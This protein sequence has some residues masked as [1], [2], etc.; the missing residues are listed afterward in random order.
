MVEERDGVWLEERSAALPVLH[1]DNPSIELPDLRQ[2]WAW[3]HVHADHD[4]EN[5]VAAAL[6]EAPDAFR[7]RLMCPRRLPAGCSWLACVVPTFE[8]G[9][10]AGLGE[11]AGVDLGLAWGNAA[12]SEVRLP[13]YH[14]W[15]FSTGEAGDFE[16]LVRRLQPRELERSVGRRDLDIGDPGG[17][18]PS[19]PGTLV[20][21]EGGLVS[22]AGRPGVWDED[23][24][25]TMKAALRK[26][27]NLEIDR[28][29]TPDPYHA[30]RDDPVVGPP[31]Y[32]A[33]QAGRRAVPAE[34]EPPLWFEE[35][36]TE[37]HR[38]VVAG[39][40]AEV[41]RNDQEALMAAAWD[42]AAGLRQ[43][44]RTLTSAR[45]AW[46]LGRR[47]QPRFATLTD[48]Q[49]VQIA[50]PA[51]SRLAHPSGLTVKGA[52]AD[53]ALPAGLVSGAFRRLAATV[54]G[55]ATIADDA[56]AGR[57]AATAAV[58]AAA[59][60]D[61]VGFVSSWGDAHPPLGCEVEGALPTGLDAPV[62]ARQARRAAAAAER[63]SAPQSE[64]RLSEQYDFPRAV[65]DDDLVTP[66]AGSVE[67]VAG[68]A[69]SVRAA[70]DPA[71][72]VVKMVEARVIGLPTDRDDDVPPRLQARPRFTTPMCER[73]IALSVE[74]LV[75]GIGAVPDN[76]LGLLEVNREFVEAFLT[77]L[78]YELARE[79]VWRE[80]PARLSATWAQQFWDT[81]PGGPADI[82]PIGTWDDDTPLGV[83]PP[84][85]ATAATLVLLLRG[86]APSPLPRPARL[87]R[88]GRVG[89]R[90]AS[91][92]RIRR[93]PTSGVRRHARARRV[94]LRL[95]ARPRPRREAARTPRSTRAGSSCWRSSPELPGSGSTR[96]A[97]GSA[98]RRRRTG[99]TCPGRTS[100]PRTS[101]CPASWT[102]TGPSWLVA[103]GALTGNGGP[104][105]WGED[106]AAMARITFQRP[107][108]ML[109]H[110]GRDA[111]G[112]GAAA[113][114][115]AP[116]PG[117]PEPLR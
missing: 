17:G 63:P 106:A 66:Y 79:F 90:Q 15:R 1:V 4:L 45:L 24:R 71:G 42:H 114:R 37:P 68:L 85:T 110:A 47:A 14:S 97:S 80:Y 19:A 72:T 89:R 57:V 78:N 39:L 115:C 59:L 35:L 76:T 21:Y 101:R 107:V 2:C 55:F 12:T 58:T 44:N 95:R 61:P 30:L 7:S 48:A 65:V 86:R 50:G 41:V 81:G 52:L 54:T 27:L 16:S 93:G 74:Y 62:A 13:V 117:E 91:R 96:R 11:P 53:S 75:P 20:T 36:N 5:G 73:L 104:D 103:A 26:T 92:G 108:R 116:R 3:A 33:P 32:G 67:P 100:S 64:P 109:V 113:I 29:P 70:L 9:R 22:P 38:R 43:V 98:R 83:H 60:A 105:A 25:E 46:E 82:A 28:G 112:G 69:G 77:G 6:A 31:A 49:V 23:H 94:L 111:A 10:R 51:M 87:R 56:T 102:S 18:L 34:G 8:A 40:G 88:R 99:R 84:P